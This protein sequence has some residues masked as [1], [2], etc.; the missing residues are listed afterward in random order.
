MQKKIKP[1]FKSC[2]MFPL[3]RGWGDASPSPAFHAYAK[4]SSVYELTNFL[5][6]HMPPWAADRSRPPTFSKFTDNTKSFGV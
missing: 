3:I 1:T 2:G 4:G 6:R 5:K